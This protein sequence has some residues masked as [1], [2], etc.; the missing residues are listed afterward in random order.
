MIVTPFIPR[1]DQASG[2]RRL[3][4]MF[5][6]LLPLCRLELV[7]LR[8]RDRGDAAY[9]E[10]LTAMGVHCLGTGRA[11]ATQAFLRST[12]AAVFFEFHHATP[13][14]LPRVRRVQPQAVVIVD[15]VDVHF[16]RERE[17]AS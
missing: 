3:V 9:V 4:A 6:L 1:A 10:Q 14:L 16:L 15:S 12:Y 11:V 5:A 7:A 8:E 17:T 13:G 2:D